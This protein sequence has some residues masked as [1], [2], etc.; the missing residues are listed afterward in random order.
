MIS[1]DFALSRLGLGKQQQQQLAAGQKLA[2]EQLA[3][4]KKL[5]KQATQQEF[6][7]YVSEFFHEALFE[8][9]EQKLSDPKFIYHEILPTEPEIP[10]LFD[11]CAAKAAGV[12]QF[13]QLISDLPW[14]KAR[15]L[16]L[17]NNPPFRA[18]GSAKPTLEKVD[19]AI[20]YIGIDNTKTALLGMIAKYWLP[21]STEPFS[22]FKEKFWR[23]SLASGNCMKSL[24]QAYGL[25]ENTGFLFGLL[26]G[27]G[28]SLTMR[29]YLRAFDAVRVEQMKAALKNDRKDIEQVLNSLEVDPNFINDALRKYSNRVTQIMFDNFDLKYAVMSPFNEELVQRL[30]FEKASKMTKA[31]MQAKTFTQYKILQSARLIE[32]DEAKM[33]LTNYR[34]N[35]EVISRLNQVNLSKF[36]FST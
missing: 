27:L 34:I 30:P 2:V 17:V 5:K 10:K 25:N 1:T 13:E 7:V 31:L 24:S 4:E 20:R 21:H 29:L 19:L 12:T 22:E 26:H 18:K 6:R 35:N 23:Y 16:H 36:T 9:L 11:A 8:Y 14:L 28:I 33:F 3:A 32:L 15:F